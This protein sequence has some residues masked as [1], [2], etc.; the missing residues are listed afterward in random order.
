M[1]HS[2][3]LRLQTRLHRARGEELDESR[4]SHSPPLVMIIVRHEGGVGVGD[5]QP[6]NTGTVSLSHKHLAVGAV[7]P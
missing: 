7:R 3:S 6:R 4:S 5:S 1:E 2:W